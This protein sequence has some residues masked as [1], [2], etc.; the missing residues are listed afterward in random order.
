MEVSV[1]LLCYR[2]NSFCISA[3][4]VNIKRTITKVKSEI[5]EM[6]VRIGVL[7]CVLLQSKLQEKRILEEDLG[8]AVSVF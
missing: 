5:S 8:T 3:P 1:L 4:L 2:F 6:D 7:E